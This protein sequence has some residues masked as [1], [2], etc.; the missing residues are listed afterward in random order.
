MVTLPRAQQRA[1]FNFNLFPSKKRDMREPDVDPGVETMMDYAKLKRM[2][3]RLPL[4]EDVID[5]VH[6]FL[7]F[8]HKRGEAIEDTHAQLI[9]PCLRYCIDCKKDGKLRDSNDRLDRDIPKLLANR[10]IKNASSA[11]AAH[12]ALARFL[13]DEYSHLQASPAEYP[14]AKAYV[15]SLCATRQ[16]AQA[17]NFVLD[18]ESRGT[19]SP[20]LEEN[21]PKE[22]EATQDISFAEDASSS[23]SIQVD[24]RGLSNNLWIRI[25]QG[26]AQLDSESDLLETLEALRSRGIKQ[27]IPVALAMLDFYLRRADLKAVRTWFSEFWGTPSSSW[28]RNELHASRALRLVL[29]WCLQHNHLEFGHEIV[30]QAMQNNPPKPMWDSIFVWAA[31]TG[32]GPDEINRMLSVMESTNSK[33]A[34]PGESRVPDIDTINALVEFATS[35]N[36]PYMAERFIVLGKERDIVPDARTYVLQIEYR[37]KVNDVDG[38]LMAYKSLQAMDLSSNEDVSTVNQLIRAL[39]NSNRHDFDTIM[40]VAADL[41]DRSARFDPSTVSTLAL[42]HLGRDEVADV[43]DLLNTHSYHYSSSEREGIRNEIAALC[44]TSDTPTSRSWDAYTILRSIFDEMPRSQRTEIMASFFARERPDMAVQVFNGMRAHS[45]GD[46]IPTVATYATAFLGSAKLRDQESLEVV[47]NQLKLDFNISVNTYLNNALI[48]AYTTCGKPRRALNFWDDIVASKEGPTYNSIH[49]TL[50]ACEESPFGDL[51][52]Q[53]VWETLR[54]QKIDLDQSM[55]ASYAGALAGNGD[56]EL[57]I[58]TLVQ[59]ERDN[60]LEMDA[61]VIGTLLSAAPGY[62]K[63]VEIEGWA[64]ERY[65]QA[66]IELEEKIGLDVDEA[67]MRKAKLD[68]TVTP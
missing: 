19:S 39:C 62:S 20:I 14:L 55:W 40:N 43:I 32:K 56:N 21:L 24:H 23:E 54:K 52:A 58:A 36:D 33:T 38:A 25:L 67:G 22:T 37:L 42:L 27:E 12:V 51:K 26:F 8:K 61:V 64:K 3:A 13:V 2:R 65:P 11:T 63:Q 68:R 66:W 10:L 49:I 9:L 15:A 57:A 41:S 30:R 34:D 44:T 4:P 47:H 29:Q 6:N 16:P 28:P 60:E 18:L 46:T 17:R 31:G 50:R 53:E 7:R 48:I 5:A 59:A 35:K 45:R 1:F